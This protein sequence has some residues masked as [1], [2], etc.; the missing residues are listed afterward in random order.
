[1]SPAD[2]RKYVG[3]RFGLSISAPPEKDPV[4]QSSSNGDP[5]FAVNQF[6]FTEGSNIL[7]EG[8]C[9]VLGHRWDDADGQWNRSGIL[10][11]LIL[12]SRD[13]RSFRPAHP[14]PVTGKTSAAILN[15][16]A[17]PDLPPPATED[18]AHRL[19]SEGVLEIRQIRPEG[20][21]AE[22][23]DQATDL[24]AAWD[25]LRSQL[26]KFARIRALTAQ[27][28]ALA[29]ESDFR[30]CIGG[31]YGKAARRLPG[32]IEEALFT[33][34]AGKPLYVSSAFGG[35]SKALADCLLRRSVKTSAEDIFYTP[36]PMVQLMQ[37]HMGEHPI[38][39]K[40]EGPSILDGWNAQTAFWDLNLEKLA[41]Q[42]GLDADQ[43]INLLATP[44]VDRAM[45]WIMA[46][47]QK[48]MRKPEN[49]SC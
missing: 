44:N 47:V 17:W 14:D 26:G 36:A 42:S 22:Y 11:H 41:A 20:F 30:I 2:S 29:R 32:V 12:K 16:V 48:L 33:A 45:A 15:L 5:E 13:F 9:L 28:L 25:L 18:E 24:K 38:A 3:A 19:I 23:L 8:G 31:N 21:T 40:S 4:W 27:R 10:N 34:M 35:V 46:G 6:V 43:Y 7:F 49:Q 39:E 37:E 1:M